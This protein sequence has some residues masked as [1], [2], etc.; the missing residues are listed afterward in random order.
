MGDFLCYASTTGADIFAVN[1]TWFSQRDIA[2]QIEVPPRV[3]MID[4]SHVGRTGGGTVLL[5]SDSA[6]EK[7]RCWRESI[8]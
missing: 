5:I 1:E 6:C 8:I 2:Y 7:S 3:K 4:H